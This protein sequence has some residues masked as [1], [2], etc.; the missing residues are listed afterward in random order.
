METYN[1]TAKGK[2]GRTVKGQVEARNERH[3][4]QVLKER[5]YFVIGL[6]K[7]GQGKVGGL[8]LKGKPSGKDVMQFSQQ[9]STMLNAGM[10]L[11]D[12]LAL[13]QMQSRSA[14]GKVLSEIAHDVQGGSSF[15]DAL[16]K[17][18]KVFSKV[19][20]ALIQAGEGSGKLDDLLIR[21]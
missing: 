11:T 12:A 20:Q 14:M 18:P 13:L 9:L 4:A 16:S 7:Q 10:P 15:S 6:K 2:D 3:A 17:H 5:N 21:L 8:S 1:Y 19:Y